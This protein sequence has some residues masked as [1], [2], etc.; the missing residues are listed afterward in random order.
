[1][2]FSVYLVPH[3]HAD[4]KEESEPSCFCTLCTEVYSLT[5]CILKPCQTHSNAVN[6]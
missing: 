2:I 3:S 1:M 5:Q 4:T 6:L